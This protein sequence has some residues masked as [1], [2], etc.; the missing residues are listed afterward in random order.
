MIEVILNGE[1]VEVAEGTTLLALLER[2]GEPHQVALVEV[3]RK[4]VHKS[5]LGRVV[6]A[7]L[8][9]VEVILPAFG[10]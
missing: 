10:G 2:L 6:L 3:N 7:P 5:E 4:L 1:P 8:D 9:A